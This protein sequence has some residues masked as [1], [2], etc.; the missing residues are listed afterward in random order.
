MLHKNTFFSLILLGSLFLACSISEKI[1]LKDDYKTHYD[2]FKVEGSFVLFDQ[3]EKSYSIYN[4][5]QFRQEFTPAST[6]K[7][8]NTLIGLETGV[9]TDENFVISWDSV[10]RQVAKWNTNHDLKMA[11]KNSTVWYY[12][13]LARRVGGTKMKQYLHKLHYGNEDTT[14]GI[15][16]FWLSGSLRI[17]PKQQIDFL[18]KLNSYKLPVSK[19]SIDILKK[20]MLVSDSNGI[21]IYAKT[22]WGSQNNLDIGWYVGFVE[23]KDNV[24]YFA[25]C[26]QSSDLNNDKFISARTEIANT[27]LKDLKIID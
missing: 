25:N 11:F 16:K 17:T 22:G 21:K 10:V 24:Y 14:G 12:Q 6:F 15:D 9:I 2:R 26:I 3:K 1:K 20:I 7:I 19:R 27:I 5:A 13:E 23:I 18:V 8:C 4:S